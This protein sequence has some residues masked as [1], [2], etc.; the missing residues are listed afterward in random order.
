MYLSVYF[1]EVLVEAGTCP[2]PPVVAPEINLGLPADGLLKFLEVEIGYLILRQV[3][4][5]FADNVEFAVVMASAGACHVA[6]DEDLPGVLHDSFRSGEYWCLLVQEIYPV[7]YVPPEGCLV[8]D[9]AYDNR[10]AC[11]SEPDDL[12][13]RLLHGDAACAVPLA[14][15]LEKAVEVFVFQRVVELAADGVFYPVGQ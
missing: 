5:L 9:I 15:E 8:R 4:C 11:T 7:V 2:L 12:A 13:Q 6:I 14:Y 1:L 3:F 10:L